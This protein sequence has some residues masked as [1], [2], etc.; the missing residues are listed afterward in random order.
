MYEH[1]H[2]MKKY[3]P[4]LG[5]SVHIVKKQKIRLNGSSRSKYEALLHV[6]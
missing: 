3:K 5:Q 1:D 4:E 6:L 2:E